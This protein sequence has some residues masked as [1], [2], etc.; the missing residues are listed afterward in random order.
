MKKV[1]LIL[2]VILSVQSATA[3]LNWK[4]PETKNQLYTVGFELQKLTRNEFAPHLEGPLPFTSKLRWQVQ[5]SIYFGHTSFYNN[6]DNYENGGSDKV[7]GYGIGLGLRWYMYTPKN[8]HNPWPFFAVNFDY[9]AIDL[10]YQAAGY[11][12]KNV[13]GVNYYYFGPIENKEDISRTRITAYAGIQLN[14]P[15]VFGFDFALGIAFQNASI[16]YN[17][18]DERYRHQHPYAHAFEGAYPVAKISI[19]LNLPRKEL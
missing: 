7:S 14:T 4:F 12:L 15:F 6:D 5:P 2:S 16:K 3:Q 13:D 1:L 9:S 10:K 19:N 8:Q 11:Y 18:T 17:G